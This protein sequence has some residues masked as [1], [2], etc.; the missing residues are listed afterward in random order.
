MITVLKNEH[1]T[2]SVKFLVSLIFRLI[3]FLHERRTRNSVVVDGGGIRVVVDGGG[4]RDLVP[5]ALSEIS[6]LPIL[7][8]LS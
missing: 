1:G 7:Y 5:Y 2:K 8:S 3:I 4:I 6:H